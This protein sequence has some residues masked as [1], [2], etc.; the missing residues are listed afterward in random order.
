MSIMDNLDMQVL[1]WAIFAGIFAGFVVIF[2][3]FLIE[4]FGGIIGGILGVTPTTIVPASISLAFTTLPG[5][6]EKLIQALY[7][8]PAGMLL[9]AIFLLT[10]NISASFFMEF[11]KGIKLSLLLVLVVVTTLLIWFVGAIIEFFTFQYVADSDIPFQFVFLFSFSFL[12]IC[13]QIFIFYLHF[14]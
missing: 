3:T 1:G 7:S 4:K 10:W 5:D 8:F 6:P 2:V 13:L 11:F 14:F 9:C 12:F